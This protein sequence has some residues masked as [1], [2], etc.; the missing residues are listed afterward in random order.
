[1]LETCGYRCFDVDGAL[2]TL[3]T[4]LNDLDDVDEVYHNAILPSQDAE[5]A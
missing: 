3:K 1:L 4:R 5:D 2:N